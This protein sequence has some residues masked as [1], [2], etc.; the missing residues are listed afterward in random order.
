[1]I[2]VTIEVEHKGRTVV[3]EQKSTVGLAY[4]HT[5]EVSKYVEK[6]AGKATAAAKNA[7][8]S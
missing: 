4:M 1:M 5:T 6:L 8:L 7:V 3:V 2:R